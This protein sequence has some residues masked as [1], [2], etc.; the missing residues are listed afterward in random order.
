MDFQIPEFKLDMSSLA[1]S[2]VPD[3]DSIYDLLILGAGPAA[4]SAAV[5]AARKMLN[6]AVI[7]R[8]FGGQMRYTPEIENYLGFQNIK[9]EDL[10][11]NFVDHVKSFDISIKEGANITRVE[12]RGGEF[13]VILEEGLSYT[14]RS[15]I[16]A[17]GKREKPLG[18]PGES[19]LIGKGVAYCTTCD[20]PLF[21]GKR[22]VVAG[23]GNSAFTAALDLLKLDAD[24]TLVNFSQGWQADEIL[25]NNVK[26]REKTRFLDN[27]QVVRIE[28]SQRVEAVIIKDRGNGDEKSL[29]VDGIFIE[30][31]LLPNSEPVSGLAELN[32]AG[33]VVVDCFCRTSVD[34][35]F[36]AGDVTTVPYKQIIISSGEG[37]KAALSAYDRLAIKGLI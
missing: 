23:G 14:G 21:R 36:A 31:G 29:K 25:Q 26:G 18:V 16:L 17:T 19:E 22:V 20:A 1:S 33:E 11:E 27:H 8:D 10:I 32:E 5:Y 30:I 35:L 24:V 9:A 13:G 2:R 12:K 34:G 3:P 4:M 28:G 6:L 15:V 37:A 7:A